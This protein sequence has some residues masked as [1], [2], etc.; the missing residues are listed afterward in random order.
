MYLSYWRV[1]D[2]EV[3]RTSVAMS[4][5]DGDYLVD[6]FDAIKGQRKDTLRRIRSKMNKYLSNCVS[7]PEVSRDIL[8]RTAK[9][10]Q[11]YASG[12]Q[13]FCDFMEWLLEHGEMELMEETTQRES[14]SHLVD[15]E[16]NDDVCDSLHKF[17]CAD[18]SGFKKMAIRA[19][20]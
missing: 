17:S 18:A 7:N 19:T 8:S 5:Q 1:L 9:S 11:N 6:M 13:K 12:W 14:V 4:M 3:F 15:D 10:Y 16:S 2:N 20:F